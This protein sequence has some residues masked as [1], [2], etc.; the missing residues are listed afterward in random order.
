M[1]ALHLSGNE[2]VKD[3]A[4]N[5]A[6]GTDFSSLTITYVSGVGFDKRAVGITEGEEV[7]NGFAGFE[8]DFAFGLPSGNMAKRFTQ[9]DTARYLISL[10][11]GTLTPSSF[12]YFAT[13]SS[14]SGSENWY[15]AAH[16]RNT[17]GPS[18]SGKIGDPAPVPEPS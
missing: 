14:P 17:S 3:W 13:A 18:G 7:V 9:G 2:D 15:T 10:T 16:I 8:F 4:F 11:G 5:I 1:K 6:P 12:D